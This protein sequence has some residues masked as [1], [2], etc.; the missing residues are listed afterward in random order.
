M[1]ER[2]AGWTMIGQDSCQRTVAQET[3]RHGGAESP[4][5]SI[6]YGVSSPRGASAT[7]QVS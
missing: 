7:V 1:G 5:S 6:D 4:W 2:E 3:V